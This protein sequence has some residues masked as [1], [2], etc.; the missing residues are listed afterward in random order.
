M[1]RR[2]F[3]STAVGAG[4]ALA[5]APVVR[6]AQ[7]SPAAAPGFRQFE[8]VTTVDLPVAAEPAQLWL[9]VFQSAG[10]YQRASAPSLK[11]SG[12]PGQTADAIFHA[13][14]VSARWLADETGRH[15]EVTQRVAV[16]GRSA[17]PA[18]ARLSSTER[19][20]WTSAAPGVPTDGLVRETALRITAG[21]AEPRAQLR[22]IY[23]WVI[24]N[25]WRNP[26][27]EG[28][29]TGDAG[30]MLR[31]GT[32]GGKCADINS[33]MVAL[34][35]SAGFPARDIYGL[36][37]ADSTLFHSLGRS[38][39]VTGAQ[40]CRAEVWLEGYGWFPVDPADV[41]KAALEEKLPVDDPRIVALANH[42]FG[43]TEGNWA[44][45]NSATGLALPGAPRENQF[46][47]MMYPAA[48]NKSKTWNCC[49]A[50]DFAYSIT[51]KELV[52]A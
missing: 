52:T 6:A 21:I 33:L 34:A 46:H 29:G 17:A 13:P 27:T 36:R 12:A 45:Y 7:P 40:H 5:A 15:L 25:T 3:V 19:R 2:T 49:N 39:T 26:A 42:L 31:T 43:N 1:D 10:D 35:R 9:P 28:C 47:F 4:A 22:A 20:L 14:L 23:D 50:K 18:H 24:A 30:E 37:V 44:G 41:R 38:G 48:M 16:R 32:L 11:G 51:S 8:V